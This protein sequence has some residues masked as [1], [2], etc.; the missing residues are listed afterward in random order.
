MLKYG[1]IA[2]K[3]N[4]M[5]DLHCDGNYDPNSRFLEVLNALVMEKNSGDYTTASHTCATKN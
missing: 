1:L 3:Y 2:L 5:I 4:V